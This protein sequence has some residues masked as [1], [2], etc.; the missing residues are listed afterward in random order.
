MNSKLK[1]SETIHMVSNNLYLFSLRLFI[2][3]IKCFA[4]YFQ[5]LMKFL[6]FNITERKPDEGVWVVFQS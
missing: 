1:A 5:L 2:K 4:I 3:A 6:A